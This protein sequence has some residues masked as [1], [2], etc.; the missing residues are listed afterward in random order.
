MI[1]D[2]PFPESKELL[3][4][5]RMVDVESDERAIEIAA[6]ASA[7]PGPGGVPIQQP[8]EVRA[9][10]ERARPGDVT[11]RARAIEDLLRE[12]APQVLGA[13]VRRYGDFADAEDAVQE[14]LLA[15]ATHW[16]AEGVPD[17]P[18][19]WLIRVAVAPDGRPAPQRAAPGGAARTPPR[20]AEPPAVAGHRPRRHADP[21]VHV[22]PPGADPGVGDRAHAAGG[23]RPDHRARSPPRSWCPR[24]PWPS[25]S[26]GPSRAS[27]RRAS[28]SRCRPASERAERLRSVL[29]VLYLIFNEGYASSSGPD[30]HRTDLSGEAIRLARMVHAALPDDPEVAGLLALMLLTD[31]RRPART[32]ADGELVPLAE[33]DRT[34]WDRELIAEG[35]A[36][37]T[38][39]LRRGQVGRVPAAG[40]DR[41]RPRPRRPASTTPTGRRS[42]RSTGCS[43]G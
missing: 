29:H 18:L 32:G 16:P 20:V 25:G 35:T 3:A 36:L 6:Q 42:S 23:R 12:L 38:D 28:R 22:L 17:N 21:A 1:T 41:R 37:I 39:A 15:A 9:G 33:Q 10:D 40:R 8:I 43:S 13:V 4:G 14:A 7:A 27:R 30:L 2:G 19:G 24:R 31:A 5:Y 26:A 34:R 11:D